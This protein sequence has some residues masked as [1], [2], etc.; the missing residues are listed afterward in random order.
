MAK[1]NNTIAII[2]HRYLKNDPVRQ[3]L[4][5]EASLNAK[6]A[7]LIYT[8]IKQAGLTQQQLA[9]LIQIKQSPIARLKDAD[10]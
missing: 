8:A 10:Y 1:T 7:Q 3:D 9:D 6:V 2:N 4:L 5:R